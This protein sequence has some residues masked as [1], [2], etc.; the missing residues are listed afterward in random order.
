MSTEIINRLQ[1]DIK[2]AMKARESE[3]LEALRFLYSEIKN[4]G[5]NEGRELT[6]DDALVVVG[7]LIKQ[8]QESIEQFKKGGREDLVAREEMGINLYR[9]Y[10]PPQLSVGELKAIVA[11]AVAETSAAG[12][13]DMGKV[14]KVL[15]PRVKGLA[16]G[17]VVNEVVREQ[18]QG[19]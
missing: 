15:M 19:V 4:V 8:R 11:E 12:L 9:E 17:K 1:D 16:E 13:K 7:R 3:K 5:I 18:L 2:V 14:M 6:D 10:L